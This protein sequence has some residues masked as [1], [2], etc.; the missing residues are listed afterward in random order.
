MPTNVTDADVFTDPVDV[1]SDTETADHASLMR[2]VQDLCNRTRYLFNRRGVGTFAIPIVASNYGG[3]DGGFSAIA[4]GANAINVGATGGSTSQLT[5]TGDNGQFQCQVFNMP[6]YGT[7]RRLRATLDG[8]AAHGGLPST[9]PRIRLVRFTA[10]GIGAD[11][12][13]VTDASASVGAYEASHVVTSGDVSIAINPTDRWY[14]AV[15]GEGDTNY[16]AGLV[17]H[18]IEVDVE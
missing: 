14:I 12:I 1:P 10:Y 2:F 9:M 3:N 15:N 5:Q 17:V 8:A 4:G 18:S 16:V 7:V 13:D 6:R 11:V